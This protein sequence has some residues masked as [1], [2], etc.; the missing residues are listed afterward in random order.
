VE[1][2]E[3]DKDV[4]RPTVEDENT[5]KNGGDKGFMKWLQDKIDKMKGWI[6]GKVKGDGKDADQ[7]KE[8]G[9]S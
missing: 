8:A 7:E 5:G 4:E 9:S 2:D 3:P 6:E 1:V